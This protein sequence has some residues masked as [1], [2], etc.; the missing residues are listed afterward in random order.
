MPNV[1]VRAATT[2]EC[3][4]GPEARRRRTGERCSCGGELHGCGGSGAPF[5]LDGRGSVGGEGREVRCC[6]ALS[7]VARPSSRRARERAMAWGRRRRKPRAARRAM[8]RATIDKTAEL[9]SARRGGATECGNAAQGGVSGWFGARGQGWAFGG[10]LNVLSPVRGWIGLT[11]QQTKQLRVAVSKVD[12]GMRQP[13]CAPSPRGFASDR[14][15]FG[16]APIIRFRAPAGIL[17][18]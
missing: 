3:G 1:L 9:G 8:K 13:R 12:H 16:R 18:K 17:C 4:C 14:I 15:F 5:G 10:G 6:A 7:P 2:T 11:P